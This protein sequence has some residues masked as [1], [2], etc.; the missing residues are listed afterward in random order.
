MAEVNVIDWQVNPF[1]A[2]RW[3]AAW[4][5]AFE[6]A[7]AFGALEATITRSEDDPLLFRQTTVWEK[8][9]DFERFWA[10]DE[11]SK[12]RADAIDYY[13]KPLLPSWHVVCA[14]GD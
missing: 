5:P 3:Y 12:A 13:N 8:R 10:S 1:R 9:E 7:K 2:E 11:A 6:R 14:T 4:M